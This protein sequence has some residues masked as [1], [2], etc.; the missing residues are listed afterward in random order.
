MSSGNQLL[1][2]QSGI[3]RFRTDFELIQDRG[4]RYPAGGQVSG[5]SCYYMQSVSIVSF[6]ALHATDP[7]AIVIW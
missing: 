2:T 6:V 5:N 7:V 4:D 3:Q 1:M